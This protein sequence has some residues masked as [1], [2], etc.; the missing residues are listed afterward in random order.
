MYRSSRV[1]PPVS[2]PIPSSMQWPRGLPVLDSIPLNTRIIQ[3]PQANT[4][5]P[6]D[7]A[8]KCTT[9]PVPA[10]SVKI[11]TSDLMLD[12][13]DC[14]K[15]LLMTLHRPDM[16]R[17][18]LSVQDQCLLEDGVQFRH[19]VQARFSLDSPG[20]AFRVTS[21]SFQNA[22]E[23]TAEFMKWYFLR[24]L[25]M[26]DIGQE[27]PLIL[28]NGAFAA[29]FDGPSSTSSQSMGS[30]SGGAVSSN[31]RDISQ[32]QSDKITLSICSRIGILQFIP[33]TKRW[34]TQI[35]QASL[36]PDDHDKC[37]AYL[38]NMLYMYTIRHCASLRSAEVCGTS[39][40]S[41]IGEGSVNCAE[42]LAT[43]PAPGSESFRSANGTKVAPSKN[44][45]LSSIKCDRS[46]INFS[47]Q[48]ASLS[49]LQS[50]M[51]P[52]SVESH[53]PRALR[54]I[55]ASI[56]GS[57]LRGSF[58]KCH[59]PTPTTSIISR[60]LF[61]PGKSVNSVVTPRDSGKCEFTL[62][63]ALASDNISGISDDDAIANSVLKHV[64]RRIQVAEEDY[65]IDEERIRKQ[66]KGP[67]GNNN[68]ITLSLESSSPP[69]I[70]PFIC[71]N[72]KCTKCELCDTTVTNNS[73]QS[74]TAKAVERIKSQPIFQLPIA[75]MTMKKSL[76]YQGI[77]SA[78]D[79]LAAT[80]KMGDDGKPLIKLTPKQKL[81]VEAVK[82][83]S[84]LVNPKAINDWFNSITYPL[85]AL[86]F[87]STAF[88]LPPFSRLLPY[89]VLPFQYSA[90]VYYEDPFSFSST[91]GRDQTQ[92]EFH[93]FCHMGKDYD[94][95]VDPRGTTG[96]SLYEMLQSVRAE[97]KR[98][99]VSVLP[100]ITSNTTQTEKNITK[101]MKPEDAL[102]K[103][104]ARISKNKS[105]KMEVLQY[106]QGCI[107]G[108]NV[109]FEMRC[110]KTMGIH[111]SCKAFKSTFDNL[112][113]MNSL[114]LVSKG[115]VHPHSKGS[116]SLKKLVPAFL[117][118]LQQYTGM[119]IQDG[120]A[121]Y[122]VYRQWYSD[123]TR[124]L[125]NASIAKLKGTQQEGVVQQSNN[126][127]K[128]AEAH[129]RAYKEYIAK[130]EAMD[131]KYAEIR[132]D[133]ITYCNMDVVQMVEV[134]KEVRRISNL[135]VDEN[136][137]QR[138]VVKRRPD[139]YVAVPVRL[140]EAT[141]P[142]PSAHSTV[143]KGE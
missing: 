41:A 76:Y 67:Y 26:R 110:F 99:E 31:T 118:H 94:P 130:K 64:A 90:A 124:N 81:F 19:L 58:F 122:G 15:R 91:D 136:N 106:G 69:I 37:R 93:T 28:Q 5:S 38:K 21:A 61:T 139:G 128:D 97:A 114:E 102:K 105:K 22:L 52:I 44:L 49:I 40:Y 13:I 34:G 72:P 137:I 96:K 6:K 84:V 33:S 101:K 92:P 127:V 95:K 43:S 14:P 35:S 56:H 62:S 18:P 111:S 48:N 85:I 66:K 129:H 20:T 55:I 17:P 57:S 79:I 47:T 74:E 4:S 133:L 100:T 104:Q 70:S 143:P 3:P 39:F 8:E 121:A 138:G 108:H 119:S 12:V 10:N 112:F 123:I 42:D 126:N 116:N 25:P 50:R 80:R 36:S 77:A 140:V 89:G 46:K 63:D 115:I 7:K 23:E 32:K 134:M 88:A 98:R 51:M 2:C 117:P 9:T 16:D 120:A 29:A 73:S 78:D 142:L 103:Y 65:K 113:F 60:D 54:S 71:Q 107:V 82:S 83:D 27:H 86:D 132:K 45:F 109:S 131:G 24:Y 75:R 87:E 30:Y 53:H 125:P 59:G 141:R 68:L 135:A 1:V 11:L